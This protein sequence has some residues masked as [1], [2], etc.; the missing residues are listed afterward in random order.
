MFILLTALAAV[1]IYFARPI[2]TPE[3]YAQ[4]TCEDSPAT[5][6]S[7]ERCVEGRQLERGFPVVPKWSAKPTPILA[8]PKNRFVSLSSSKHRHL[9]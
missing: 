9:Y 6:I 5:G 3:Q 2:E 4:R 7:Y 1:L 8:Y